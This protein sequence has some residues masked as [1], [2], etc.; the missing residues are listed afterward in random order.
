[1][2]SIVLT[3]DVVNSKH[4]PESFDKWFSENIKK[5]NNDLDK[6]CSHGRH[7]FASQGDECQLFMPL[8]TDFTMTL[9]LICYHLQPKKLRFGIGIGPHEGDIVENSWNMNGPIFW[10]AK[11]KLELLKDEKELVAQI[12]VFENSIGQVMSELMTYVFE[13]MGK[14]KSETWQDVYD[15]VSIGDAQKL[16]DK[17]NITLD[18]YYKRIQRSQYKRYFTSLSSIVKSVGG[19]Q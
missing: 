14:W 3:I 10:I 7:V 1:M 6:F 5:I 16:A 12:G 17:R 19:N 4:S 18:G 9:F 8:H 2:L 11:E 13:A 15:D